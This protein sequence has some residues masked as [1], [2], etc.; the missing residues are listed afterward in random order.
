MSVHVG[1]PDGNG[2]NYMSINETNYPPFV[3]SV[4]SVSGWPNLL[5]P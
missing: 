5:S 2:P 1:H 4:R 3:T